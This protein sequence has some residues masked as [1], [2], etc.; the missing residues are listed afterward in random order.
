M[1]NYITLDLNSP[2]I[3]NEMETFYKA[4][5]VHL[6]NVSSAHDGVYKIFDLALKIATSKGEKNCKTTLVIITTSTK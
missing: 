4:H 2:N 6:A 5:E 3:N 1:N